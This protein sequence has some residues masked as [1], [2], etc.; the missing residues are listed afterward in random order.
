MIPT[1]LPPGAPMARF[2]LFA[3]LHVAIAFACHTTWATA[4][5]QVGFIFSSTRARRWLDLATAVAMA[6]LAARVLFGFV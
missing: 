2:A 1:F 6:I 4:F 3:G 5:N